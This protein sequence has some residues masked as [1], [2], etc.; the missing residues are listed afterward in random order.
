MFSTVAVIYIT[1][2]GA[3]R[4]EKAKWKT[5]LE[6]ETGFMSSLVFVTSGYR[7][8]C[9]YVFHKCLFTTIQN[10][11]SPYFLPTLKTL[12]R[13]WR[14]HTFHTFLPPWGLHLQ[15]SLQ[16]A[17]FFNMVGTERMIKVRIIWLTWLSPHKILCIR[18]GAF[19]IILLLRHPPEKPSSMRE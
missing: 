11:V 4:E 15:S 17:V 18:R 10:S 12:Q 16:S 6:T 1:T 7:E 2:C 9:S 14:S 13:S 3:S 8:K 5:S 19:I